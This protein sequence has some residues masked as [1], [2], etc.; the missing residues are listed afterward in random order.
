VSSRLRR[1]DPDDVAAARERWDRG[2]A[3]RDDVRFLVKD[4]LALLG[5]LAPGSS[6]EVRVPP[7]AAVQVVGGTAHKRGT[8]PAVVETSPCT[9]LE[10]AYGLREWAA[11]LAA[12]EVR[13]SGERSDL[14]GL[15]PL[16]CAAG[17]RERGT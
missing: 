14:S 2:E 4:S 12:G 6:V 15:L 3:G 17:S 16:D 8:P 5:E 7:Y 11:V 13:A 10:L 9:W 1:G